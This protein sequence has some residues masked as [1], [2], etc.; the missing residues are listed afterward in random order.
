M[1][2]WKSDWRSWRACGRRG[3]LT[4]NHTKMCQIRT[5]GRANLTNS[6]NLNQFG[7][8][9]IP[10]SVLTKSR[11][12]WTQK[13]RCFRPRAPATV[14]EG[15][16]SSMV[17][18]CQQLQLKA[19]LWVADMVAAEWVIP[20]CQKWIEKGCSRM[21]T[22]DR[23]GSTSHQL[24]NIHLVRKRCNKFCL[25]SD[26]KSRGTNTSPSC[27]NWGNSEVTR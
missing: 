7:I 19:R 4:F 27:Q 2:S 26:S 14:T 13:R 9:W 18:L 12:Q 15:N 24:A 22:R 3:S 6:P 21:T 25:A 5:T 17:S 1:K 16:S 20:R 8:V 10:G 11:Y 23:R